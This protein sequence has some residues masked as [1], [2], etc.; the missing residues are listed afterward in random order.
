MR[1]SFIMLITLL[2]AAVLLV[3]ASAICVSELQDSVSVTEEVLA[4][5]PAAANGLQLQI[6]SVYD[7]HLVWDSVFSPAAAAQTQTSF[8]FV[9]NLENESTDYYASAYLEMG[10]LNYTMHFGG[11]GG[12]DLEAEESD[13]VGRFASDYATMLKPAIDVASRTAA[14]ETRTETLRL[15]DYYEYFKIGV[16]THV[17]GSKSGQILPDEA[18]SAAQRAR[19]QELFRIPVS[20]DLTVDVSVTKDNSG[21]I[22]EVCCNENKQSTKG[23]V[24]DACAEEALYGAFVGYEDSRPDL[25]YM[26]QGNGIYTIPMDKVDGRN[27]Y[28]AVERMENVYP[29]PVDTMVEAVLMADDGRHLLLFTK[30]D[31]QFVLT[32]IRRDTM[33]AVQH[34]SFAAQYRPAVW[35]SDDLLVVRYLAQEEERTYVRAYVRQDDAYTLWM[36]APF[37]E[38]VADNDYTMPEIVFDGSRL[39]MGQLQDNWGVSSCWLQV[40]DQSGLLY[41][42]RYLHSGDRVPRGLGNTGRNSLRL[43]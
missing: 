18:Q 20:E 11:A 43:T 16:E 1:R 6:Q 23:V 31:G 40:F 4:G 37:C 27:Y 5:D 26:P 25:S 34:M 21:A 32:V 17:G 12:G 36:E 28:A 33:Q 3:S 9:S 10:I 38:G 19:V 2:L 7:N 39:A 15:R 30:E 24:F 22:T 29:L 42:G 14:G 8:Q 13:P 35:R 41:G